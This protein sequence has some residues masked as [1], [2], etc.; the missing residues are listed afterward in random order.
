MSLVKLIRL[1]SVQLLRGGMYTQPIPELTWND[2]CILFVDYLLEGKEH[3][4]LSIF[5]K[6][7]N[8]VGHY[9]TKKM[10]S[11]AKKTNN[12]VGY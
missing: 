10:A 4:R 1:E 7:K 3:F 8:G 11:G 12:S 2:L 9:K 5:K 6:K